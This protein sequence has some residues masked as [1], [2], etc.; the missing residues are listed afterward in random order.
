VKLGNGAEGLRLL[1]EMISKGL[2]GYPEA[3]LRIIQYCRQARQPDVAL[4]GNLSFLFF[5]PPSLI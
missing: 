4:H 5:F 3:F 1:R 2:A